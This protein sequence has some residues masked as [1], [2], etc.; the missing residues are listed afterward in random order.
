MKVI[1]VQIILGVGFESWTQYFSRQPSMSLLRMRLRDGT[2]YHGRY[3]LSDFMS[4][5]VDDGW[6]TDEAT[7][8]K[9]Q[10]VFVC[11]VPIGT[12]SISEKN[13]Y[14]CKEE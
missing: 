12:I 2:F 5:V 9:S 13:V 1:K 3:N 14:I 6:Q 7:G 8:D 11:G 4:R 10:T